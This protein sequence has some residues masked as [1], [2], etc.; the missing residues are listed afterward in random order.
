MELTDSY[1]SLEKFAGEWERGIE[2]GAKKKPKQINVTQSYLTEQ[3]TFII[4]QFLWSGIWE[5][6]SWMVLDW[7]L[8]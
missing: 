1:H 6:L 7:D 8:S 4:S 3:S 2:I 5:P